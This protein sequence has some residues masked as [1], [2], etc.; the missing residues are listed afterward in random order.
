MK[1]NVNYNSY[2][3]DKYLKSNNIILNDTLLKNLSEYISNLGNTDNK[4]YENN[5]KNLKNKMKYKYYEKSNNRL[6]YYLDN[7]L[8]HYN[9]KSKVITNN[10]FNNKG[11]FSNYKDF[12]YTN[13]P[14]SNKIEDFRLV[15]KEHN[16]GE[17][18]H[19]QDSLYSYKKISKVM[20]LEY[21]N[22][23][24]EKVF[25]T[26]TLPSAYHRYKTVNNRL[27]LNK[28]YNDDYFEKVVKKS[29]TLLNEMH[30]Y[31]Y[32]TLKFKLKR[33]LKKQGLSNKI[34]IDFIKILEPHK[35]MTGHLH[36]LFYIDNKYLHI[37]KE[38]YEMTIKKYNLEQCKYELL[39]NSKSSS[40]LNKYLL[41]TTKGE[42]QFYNHY[43]RYF[44]N[45]RFFSCSNFK[46]SNQKS[47][48]MVY[49]YLNK[50][51]YKL[52][53][54]LKNSDIPIYVLIEKMIKNKTFEFT[55]ET[56][57]Q[58]V[59]NYDKIEKDFKEHIKTKSIEQAHQIIK[60]NLQIYLI[61]TE[62]K[63]ISKITYKNID[64]YNKEDTIFL[65]YDF[66]LFK[67]LK[68]NPFKNEEIEDK[69]L[70]AS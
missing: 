33:L 46:F 44:N 12:K 8:L 53:Q 35:N 66:E 57:K 65:D 51:K 32:H 29:L 60:E 54:R 13:N 15:Y 56:K 20:Y 1:V 52:L 28:N 4:F 70:Y 26:F 17:Y 11:C 43:K 58:I 68:N 41:K 18:L 14:K 24:K 62:I 23:D 59:I 69:L 22:K 27:V 9:K 36:S 3:I 31:F 48:E 38:V 21:H 40:Y 16:Q 25:I 30:R 47:I 10:S 5:I 42:Q 6:K 61:E 19:N 49:K 39:N 67:D 64:I 55:N 7:F 34:D 37:I 63:V 50:N 45:I 2:Q